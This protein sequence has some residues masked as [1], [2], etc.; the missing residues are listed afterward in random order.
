MRLGAWVQERQRR[1]SVQPQQV[2]AQ[3]A[4]SARK[5]ALVRQAESAQE[6]G[7]AVQQAVSA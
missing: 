2:S 6:P 1:V 3:L 4:E 7:L 5:P